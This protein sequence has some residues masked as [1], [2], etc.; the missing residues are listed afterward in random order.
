MLVM[1]FEQK[2]THD[3]KIVR[4][5][6]SAFEVLYATLNDGIEVDEDAE[7]EECGK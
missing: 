6:A 7:R 3:C 1:G 2:L 4:I 5:E